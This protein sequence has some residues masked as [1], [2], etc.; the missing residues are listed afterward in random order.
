MI[1]SVVPEPLE[2]SSS[3]S[4]KDANVPFFKGDNY[5]LWSLMMK[6]MFRSKDLWKLVEKIQ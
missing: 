2:M 1:L 4:A 6:T 5:N 3:S